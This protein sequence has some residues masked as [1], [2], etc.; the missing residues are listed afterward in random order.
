MSM[1]IMVVFPVL[2]DK[3]ICHYEASLAEAHQTETIF[4]LD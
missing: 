2:T 3:D 1:F 4:L